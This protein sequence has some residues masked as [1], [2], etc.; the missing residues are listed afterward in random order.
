MRF[1][2]LRFITVFTLA[3]VAGCQKSAP[4]E[5]KASLK[6]AMTALQSKNIAGF[7]AKVLPQ[8]RVTLKLSKSIKNSKTPTLASIL[9]MKYFATIKAF[10]ILEDNS[11]AIDDTTAELRVSFDYPGGAFTNLLFTLKKASGGWFIDMSETIDLQLRMNGA[12]AFS[13]LKLR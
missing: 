10:K 5:A 11:K 13:A 3:T 7:T 2:H 1:A 9:S 6:A 12:S 4:P 8:Q